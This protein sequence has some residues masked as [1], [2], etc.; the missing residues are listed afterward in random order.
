MFF[1]SSANYVALISKCPLCAIPWFGHINEC[2]CDQPAL[3]GVFAFPLKKAPR[4]TGKRNTQE[5]YATIANKLVFV[6]QAILRN[7]D[8]DKKVLENIDIAIKES[9]Q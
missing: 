7:I 9:F 5:P 3:T 6:T 8:I 4:Y 1:P 2:S